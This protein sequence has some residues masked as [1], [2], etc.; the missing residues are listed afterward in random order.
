MASP[1]E[2]RSEKYLRFSRRSMT[3]LLLL[4]IAVGGFCVVLAFH[5]TSPVWSKAMVPLW[6]VAVVLA[7]S[8]QRT[9]GGDRWDRRNPEVRAIVD[10]EWR[11]R[12]MDRAR[13]VAFAVVL[14]VQLPLGLLLSSLP[15]LQAVMAMAAATIT[16]GLATLLGLFLYFDRDLSD[17]G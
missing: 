4:I 9:L 7:L 16:L 17:A 14:A 13:S 5:P 11:R 3:V 10:D 15:P 8:I 1:I 6:I 2:S 12:N